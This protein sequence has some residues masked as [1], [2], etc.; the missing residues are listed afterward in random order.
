[1]RFRDLPLG[2]KIMIGVGGSC[3]LALLLACVISLAAEIVLARSEMRESV[4]TLAA[5][6]GYNCSAPLAF[7]DE[8]AARDVLTSLESKTAVRVAVLY[9]A[10]G[11]A[12][13]WYVRQGSG[14]SISGGPRIP[15]SVTPRFANGE[16]AVNYPIT[17]N[18]R[19]MGSVYIRAGTEEIFGRIRWLLAA[20]TGAFLISIA[21]ALLMARR[22]GRIVAGPIGVL[23]DTARR[24]SHDRDSAVQVVAET[25]DEVGELGEAFNHMLS[26]LREHDVALGKA[27]KDLEV[28]VRQRTRE[29]SEQRTAALNMMED[30]QEAR[31]N[32]EAAEA[33]LRVTARKLAH[34][35]EE[36]E[37]FA[38]IAS[39]DLQEPLR[40]VASYVQ[41]LE[42]RYKGRLDENA[43]QFI[44]YA[45]DGARRMQGL[46]R[47]LL[48]YSR[49]TTRGKPL[50]P[51]AM[52]DV[53][54]MTLRN[55]QAAIDEGPAEVTHDPLP[56]V[57][58]DSIQLGQLLQNLIGNA[59]KYR[60][61]TAPRVHV[62]AQQDG[63]EWVF[64]VQDNGIGIDPVYAER[65]FVIFERLH[66][67]KEYSGTGIGLAVCKRIVERHGG[68]IWVRSEVGGG[69]TFFFSLPSADSD[70]SE[71][72]AA[73]D[74]GSRGEH[75]VGR[76]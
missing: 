24:V 68:K 41:I 12:L 10:E 5:V 73:D 58:G 3:A 36:L 45:V 2:H 4:R 49:V 66:T 46:I 29:L 37:Q 17:L 47:D 60:G 8:K 65:I 25:R 34:S 27:R 7:G 1:M 74:G 14:A 76:G 32:A 57:I 33:R 42:R 43:D 50:R 16:L 55:L 21:V 6:I 61:D 20:A 67:Q 59:I 26:Q 18:D 44:A 69:A 11:H 53:L 51:T 39:H 63:D 9:T 52:E 31:R 38:Y 71:M 70:N 48:E 54:E 15:V 62:S 35:N 19:M 13:G 28:K 23:T 40:M 30:A 64:S 56:S 22:I 75:P 72:E